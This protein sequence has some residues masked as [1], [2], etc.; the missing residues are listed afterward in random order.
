MYR[1]VRIFKWF[2]P[3]ILN[4]LNA[5]T[6]N[7]K[8]TILSESHITSSPYPEKKFGEFARRRLHRLVAC[9]K[10]NC[11]PCAGLQYHPKLETVK[12][13]P[14]SW[15]QVDLGGKRERRWG[16][17]KRVNS[18]PL[19]IWRPELV[20]GRKTHRRRMMSKR[21]LCFETRGRFCD[22]LRDNR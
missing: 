8:K 20:F 16:N 21:D 9:H 11:R 3:G 2:F 4:T 17:T 19:Y 6:K 18:F 14:S 15:Y 10:R 5:Q 13:S 7:M 1:N 12:W 22:I